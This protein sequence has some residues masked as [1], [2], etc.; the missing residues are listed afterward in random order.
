MSKRKKLKR[1]RV[2]GKNLH[3]VI[4]YRRWHDRGFNAL[5]RKSFIYPLPIYIHDELHKECGP[6]PIIDEYEARVMWEQFK[7]VDHEMRLFEGLGWL[8]DHAPNKEFKDAIEAQRRF[9]RTNL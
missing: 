9:L 1:K 3:H 2:N 5:L 8:I 6:V 7:L 4:Y